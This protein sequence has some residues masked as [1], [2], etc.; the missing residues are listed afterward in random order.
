MSARYVLH[1]FE[2]LLRSVDVAS[3]YRHVFFFNMTMKFDT[4]QCE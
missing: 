4:W 2:S 3:V 1:A